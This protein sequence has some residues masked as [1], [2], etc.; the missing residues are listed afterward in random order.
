MS[1]EAESFAP[2]ECDVITARP[3]A[4][5]ILRAF[6]SVHRTPTRL[7]S[8]L[9]R[10]TQLVLLYYAFACVLTPQ[11]YP[12]HVNYIC[13]VYRVLFM[14]CTCMCCTCSLIHSATN[15]SVLRVQFECFLKARNHL[16]FVY[17]YHSMYSTCT[18]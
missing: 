18:F 17:L 16:K 2:R 7:G 11:V 10:R 6:A 1:H 3:I 9:L 12:V 15:G 5:K 8:I 13:T 4:Q 14:F